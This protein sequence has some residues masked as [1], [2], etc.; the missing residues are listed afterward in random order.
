MEYETGTLKPTR[1]YISV[2]HVSDVSGTSESWK[3]LSSIK[4]WNK[5][6]AG[7][8]EWIDPDTKQRYDIKAYREL[9]CKGGIPVYAPNGRYLG[10]CPDYKEQM[11]LESE[12]Y[13]LRPS[14]KYG[15]GE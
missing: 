13:T 3:A 7:L 9:N 6:R 4:I 2:L 1:K 14:D 11:R 8:D 12:G 5:Y 10:Y 15:S